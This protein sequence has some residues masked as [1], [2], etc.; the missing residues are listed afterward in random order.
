MLANRA[1]QEAEFTATLPLVPYLPRKAL[2]QLAQA[3]LGAGA[4]I[5]TA[6]HLGVVPPS[7]TSAAGPAHAVFVNLGMQYPPA[8]EVPER[9]N[10]ACVET[11]GGTVALH[12]TVATGGTAEVPAALLEAL[13][14]LGLAPR[15]VW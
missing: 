5:T 12:F 6:S 11:P 3:A 7:L 2:R 13:R 15:E 1:Q 10:A 14:S 8:A 9:V 4:P